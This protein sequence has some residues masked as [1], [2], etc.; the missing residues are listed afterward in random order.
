MEL[1]FDPE[2]E[3][4]FFVARDALIDRF[5]ATVPGDDGTIFDVQLGLDWKW[6]YS[7]GDLG[8]WTLGELEEFV[9]E[10]CPRKVS[11]P[12]EEARSLPRSLSRFVDFL[13]AEG[14][15]SPTSDP[16]AAL[17]AHLDGMGVRAVTA[18]ADP[19]RYGMAKSLISGMADLGVTPEGPGGMQQLMDRFN[20]L[21]LAERDRALGM[22]GLRRNPWQDLSEGIDLPPAAI[23]PAEEVARLAQA[24]RVLTNARAVRDFVGAGRKLTAKGNLG[25]ADAKALAEILGDPGLAVAAEHGRV[26]RSADELPLTQFVLRWAR[27]AGALRVVHSTLLATASWERLGPRDAIVRAVEVLLDSGPVSL[28]RS[29]GRWGPG[30]LTKVVDEGAVYLLALLWAVPDIMRFDELFELVVE[31]CEAQLSFPVVG[32]VESRRRRIRVEVDE[33]FDV[34]AEAGLVVRADEQT[35]ADDHGG[36]DRTGGT[37][38]LSRLAR[39]ALAPVLSSRG[40]H[41]PVP[42]E[43]AGGPLIDLFAV[44]GSWHPERSRVEFDAWVQLHSPEEAV[45]ELAGALAEYTDPQWPV[46]ALD[47][48]GRLGPVLEERAVRKMLETP[49]RGHALGWLA[50]HGDR[51]T[52]FEPVAMLRAGVELMSMHAGGDSDEE[53]LEL[54]RGIDDLGGFIEEVWPLPVPGALVVLEGIARVHPDKATAKAARKAVFRHRSKVANMRSQSASAPTRAGSILGP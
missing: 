34:L 28:R 43:L 40:F 31:A 46:A 19:R 12:A 17:H 53:F 39:A 33:L 6:G 1:Y 27:A 29:G 8:R 10:W 3:K 30:A 14:L 16:L 49:A 25:V 42:G 24:T 23:V 2:D 21:P 54:I 51:D 7:D 9:I 26:I 45:D 18:M 13:A 47:L 32:S 50:E 41:I 22:G 35:P 48:A 11:M 44:I 15:L 52:E 36:V 20:A 38:A 5:A 4:G 37:L